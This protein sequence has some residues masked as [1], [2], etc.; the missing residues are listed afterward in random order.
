MLAGPVDAHLLRQVQISGGSGKLGPS[1]LVTAHR[2]QAGA[3][4]PIVGVVAVAGCSCSL[5]R[6]GRRGARDD[7]RPLPR[8]RRP[9]SEPSQPSRR[10][11]SALSRRP[12][13]PRRRHRPTP[14]RRAR[15]CRSPCG[16]RSTRRRSSCCC[17]GTATASTTAACKSSVDQL[18]APRRQVA[19]FTTRSKNLSRYTRIT[20]TAQVTQTPALVIVDRRGQAPRSRPATTTS[21]TIDQFVGPHARASRGEASSARPGRRPL[22]RVHNWRVLG[23][24]RSSSI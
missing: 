17:S 5:V 3:C 4:W 24:L 7:A 21:T 6:S 11:R 14:R 18:S 16:A 13:T 12:P 23:V 22:R 2:T 15:A 20:A 10:P 9:R 1:F 8:R 19:V